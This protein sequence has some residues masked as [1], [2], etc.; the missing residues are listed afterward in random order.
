MRV[1]PAELSTR[2]T[3]WQNSPL[4]DDED[5]SDI[6]EELGNRKVLDHTTDEV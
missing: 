4:S 6:E 5:D 1:K 3:Y 2:A